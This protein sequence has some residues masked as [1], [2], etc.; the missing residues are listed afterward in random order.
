[1]DGW[2][3]ILFHAEAFFYIIFLCRYDNPRERMRVRAN[4]FTLQIDLDGVELGTTT[5][6]R[7]YTLFI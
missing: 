3:E 7:P 6:V 2:R 5:E 4:S 1:M